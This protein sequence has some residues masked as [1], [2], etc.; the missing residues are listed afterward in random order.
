MDDFE[1]GPADGDDGLDGFIEVPMG[2]VIIQGIPFG[3][4]DDDEHMDEEDGIPPEILEMLRVTEA[5]HQN[6]MAGMMGGSPFGPPRLLSISKAD[7]EDDNKP[8]VE[9]SY[10]D[11]MSRMNKL[12][13]EIGEKHDQDK[14]AK[15]YEKKSSRMMQ[16]LAATGVLLFIILV[17]FVLSC[18]AS[19]RKNED[20]DE[21]ERQYSTSSKRVGKSD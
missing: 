10:D 1:A 2:G 18:F 3:D 20:R 11:I 16:V 13:H 4:E 9:E 14:L 21:D 7:E 17:S 15:L 8:R 5:M 19:K 6:A 12:S